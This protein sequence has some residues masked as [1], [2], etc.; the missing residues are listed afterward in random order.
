M[1][2]KKLIKV[3]LARFIGL[4]GSILSMTIVLPFISS[5]TESYGIYS[6]VLSLMILLQFAD[7]G[8]LGAGQ[9]YAAEYYAMDNIKLEIETLSFVHF[10]LFVS[11]IIYTL[12]LCLVYNYPSIIF[13]DL[14]S[15]SLKIAKKLIFIFIFFSPVIVFQRYISAIYIIR[16]EDYIHQTIEIIG[17]FIKIL[18]VFYFFNNN[19]YDLVGYVFFIQTIN[20]LTCFVNIFIIRIRYKYQLTHVLK[21]FKFNSKIFQLTKKMAISSVIMS[22]S[23][24]LYYELDLVY[25]SK[26][27]NTSIV[28]FFAIGVTIL[29]FSRNLMNIIFSPFQAKFN[30]F[31][32]L[33][34]EKSLNR[35]F[36]Q[37][38]ELS[39][40]ISLISTVVIITLMKPL[41]VSWI[42]I[43]YLQSVL[44]GRILITTLMFSFLLVP[45]SYLALTKEKYF[46]IKL[47]AVSLPILYFLFFF[48][49]KFKFQELAIPISKAL[50]VICSLIINLIFLRK[51]INESLV[52]TLKRVFM[53]IIIP[54]IFLIILLY[55]LE[56]FWN[57]PYEK[58]IINF[59]QIVF[60][61]AFIVF[62][63][64]A[65]YY[66]KNITCRKLIFNFINSFYSR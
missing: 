60:V 56:P 64:L 34:D 53:D 46:F 42:G 41:I 25:V 62:F 66:Y 13:S 22:F 3:Y 20:L 35:M 59:L 44:I 61:G 57:I 10:V 24:I 52:P 30:H 8:F 65:I 58:N 63:S 54:F 16:I 23:W 36:F 40:P 32:G 39:F 37:L 7:L 9:K 45:I 33:K 18:S 28:A 11:V 12:F 4:I 17:N 43:E 50:T 55:V 47:N 15:E 27:F 14:S 29:S 48:I 2:S 6:I 38:I 31:R 5:D 1:F 49:L 51:I 21:S 19:K 26:L